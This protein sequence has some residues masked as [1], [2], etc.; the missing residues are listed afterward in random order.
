MLQIPWVCLIIFRSY[1]HFMSQSVPV[2]V[3]HGSVWDGIFD[4]SL[5][6]PLLLQLSFL[7]LDLLWYTSSCF[8][9]PLLC[10]LKGFMDHFLQS[11]SLH[12]CSNEQETLWLICLDSVGQGQRTFPY[13]LFFNCLQLKTI[14]LSKWH[15]LGL[16]VLFPFNRIPRGWSPR[17]IAFSWD[18]LLNYESGFFLQILVLGLILIF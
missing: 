5:Q 1:Q 15:I 7:S 6:S 17:T 12:L 3:S 14:N 13:L 16:Y 8:L 11:W 4:S 10:L 9:L 18:N 2:T